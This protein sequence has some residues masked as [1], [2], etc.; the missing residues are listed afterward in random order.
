[1]KKELKHLQTF[2][3]HTDKNLNISDVRSSS[4]FDEDV[5]KWGKIFDDMKT[6]PYIDI[7][8][9]R[10]SDRIAIFSWLSSN[11]H[12]PIKKDKQQWD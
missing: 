8:Q 2:E 9:V 6:S 11:F 10:E 3:Q 5:I 12:A 7:E 1:M 4:N